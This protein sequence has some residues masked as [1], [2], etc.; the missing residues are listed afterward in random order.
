MSR[1]ELGLWADHM[2]DFRSTVNRLPQS[3]LPQSFIY[4]RFMPSTLTLR[5]RGTRCWAKQRKGK[6]KVVVLSET[7]QSCKAA[8]S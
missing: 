1:T 2:S 3:I 6:I 8:W 7:A 4:D 5:L